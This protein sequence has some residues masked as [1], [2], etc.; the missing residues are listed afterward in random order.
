MEAA[1]A[2]TKTQ[3]YAKQFK[4]IIL[5]LTCIW[6]SKIHKWKEKNQ[7]RVTNVA[8]TQSHMHL[9]ARVPITCQPCSHAAQQTRYVH[10]HAYVGANVAYPGQIS[11]PP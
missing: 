1:E 7:R 8:V 3:G 9:S 2:S 4:E 6:C 10:G 11:F 5:A